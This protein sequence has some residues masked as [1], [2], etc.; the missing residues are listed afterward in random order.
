MSAAT[1]FFAFLVVALKP[2]TIPL[3]NANAQEFPT[4]PVCTYPMLIKPGDFQVGVE[5]E[6]PD[7]TFQPL[8]YLRPAKGCW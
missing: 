2:A 3:T 8:F 6:H 5:I 7:G 1:A 4:A